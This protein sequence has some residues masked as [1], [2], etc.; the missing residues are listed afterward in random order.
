MERCIAF[1]DPNKIFEKKNIRQFF[2]TFFF[3][4]IFL[5]FPSSLLFKAKKPLSILQCTLYR[6]DR[7][8]LAG[9]D[10]DQFSHRLWAINYDRLLFCA[11][12]YYIVAHPSTLIYTHPYSSRLMH[13]HCLQRSHSIANIVRSN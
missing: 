3:S 13:A 2:Q 12:V 7:S 8:P 9:F 1:F 6:L 10:F 5:V 11:I 4:S